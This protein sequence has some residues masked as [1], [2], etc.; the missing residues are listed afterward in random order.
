MKTL[1]LGICCLSVLA[2]FVVN[3]ETRATEAKIRF[4]TELNKTM[5]EWQARCALED[6]RN[7]IGRRA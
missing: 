3:Y 5:I 2:C 4:Q 1:R 6:I 7:R